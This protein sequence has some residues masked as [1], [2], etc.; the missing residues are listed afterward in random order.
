MI[1]RLS[2]AAVTL[3]LMACQA[4]TP[5]ANP[6]APPPLSPGDR[7]L[8]ATTRVA[9]PPDNL[10]PSTF[11]GSDTPDGKLEMQFCAQCHAVPSPTTHSAVEWPAVV[12]R[13]WLRMELLPDTF[14]I[15]V[16]QVGDRVRILNY[17]T[18]NALKMSPANLP[19]GRGQDAFIATCSRCHALPDPHAHTAQDWPAVFLRMEGNMQRMKVSQ[20]TQDQTGLIL[21]YL[22]EAAG[23]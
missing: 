16:P 8:L 3:A 4:G 21:G 2:A 18:T 11:P 14:N 6:N 17:L 19:P 7:L 12:R 15:Q 10:D 22:E 5:P 13:M 9:L 1:R 23:R 20:P